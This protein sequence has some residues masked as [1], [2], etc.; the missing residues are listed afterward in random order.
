[1]F[2][3]LSGRLDQSP[4]HVNQAI[5]ACIGH[6]S[7]GSLHCVSSGERCQHVV[8]KAARQ[9]STTR[10]WLPC[11]LQHLFWSHLQAHAARWPNSHIRSEI[12]MSHAIFTQS[13]KF[14]TW[15][16]IQQEHA[17]PGHGACILSGH[18]HTLFQGLAQELAEFGNISLTKKSVKHV[19]FHPWG[20]CQS[21]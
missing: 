15:A 9:L 4:L 19:T 16:T 11:N 7:F 1:V 5:E 10:L 8:S 14:S 17:Q 2:A 21:L 3:L 12:T 18:K 20:N 6:A 13:C